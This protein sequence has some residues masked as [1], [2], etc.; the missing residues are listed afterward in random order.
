MISNERVEKLRR[1]YKE[2]Y[3]EEIS[4]VDARAMAVRL[5]VLYRLLMQPLP[6]EE[7][8]PP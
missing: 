6:G 8:L 2:V 5:L 4:I 7:A 3:G 1:I